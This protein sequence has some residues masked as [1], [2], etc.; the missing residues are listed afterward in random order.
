MLK[1]SMCFINELSRFKENIVVVLGGYWG[2]MKN[3][4]DHAVKAGIQTMF[5]LPDN[6]PVMPPNNEN[7]I[8]VQTDLGFP[9]RS[10]IMCKTGDILV[11]MGGSIGSIIE[12]M[13]SYDFGKP[14]VVVKSGRETD[15]V[16]QCFDKYIDH[17]MKAELLY[18]SD[19]CEAG[20]IVVD[21]IR[22]LLKK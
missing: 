20:R 7:T 13:L 21:F 14:I 11:A 1:N 12:I 19:G 9:T 2:L 5:I 6:P 16:P 18:A 10:T 8:I 17:R 22:E 15:R 4:A 3:I